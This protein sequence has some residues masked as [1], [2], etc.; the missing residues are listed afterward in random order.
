MIVKNQNQS[1]NVLTLR[2][3]KNP[4]IAVITPLYTGH[5]ISLETQK[6]IINNDL[7]FIWISVMSENNI[8]T[9]LQTGL[10]YLI[11]NNSL[12]DYYFMLDRDIILGEHIFDKLYNRLCEQPLTCAYAYASFEFKG[13][14]NIKFPAEEW[15]IRRLVQ[16]NYISSN[17]LF[18]TEA[19]QH[20]GLVTD[21]KYKRLLDWAMLLKMAR[22]GYH[23]INVPEASFIA[24][25]EKGDISAG[26]RED[27]MKKHYLVVRDFV[28]G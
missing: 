17:S 14:L 9:N 1:Q 23:G 27:Y 24:K 18:R 26:S 2:E 7:P 15:H 5:Q 16:A 8:P 22:A 11:K 12:P 6:T 3:D 28:V 25:S 10:E 21:N 13:Y 19:V 20:V 4:R